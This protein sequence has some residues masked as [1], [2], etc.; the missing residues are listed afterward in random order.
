M[1]LKIKESY[2]KL[3]YLGTPISATRNPFP[4][5][6]VR[7][8]MGLDG[9][10]LLSPEKLN[11]STLYQKL[12]KKNEQNRGVSTVFLTRAE[13]ISGSRELR[14]SKI[15][16]RRFRRDHHIPTINLIIRAAI[17]DQLPSRIPL[18]NLVPQ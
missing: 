11:K 16:P 8:N 13:I 5:W 6:K 2:F 9:K 7:I 17:P 14:M 18:R 3:L 15:P 4:F 1:K 12:E 10:I